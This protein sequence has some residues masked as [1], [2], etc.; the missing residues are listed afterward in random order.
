M[1]GSKTALVALLA[2]GLLGTQIGS[3]TAA[4]TVSPGIAADDGTAAKNVIFKT[5]LINLDHPA[6]ESDGTLN[7]TFGRGG[8][9]LGYFHPVDSG[10]YAT[11]GGGLS[12]NRIHLDISGYPPINGTYENGAIT[13]YTFINEETH[14]FTAVRSD[15]PNL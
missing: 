9:I 10:S 11:V 5:T 14:R 1:N 2:A 3:A 8:T 13:G 4:A 12:G 15:E 7:L 6:G